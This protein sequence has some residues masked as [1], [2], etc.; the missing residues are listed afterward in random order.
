MKHIANRAIQSYKGPW[1]LA[2]TLGNV[3]IVDCS[4]AGC[5]IGYA[6]SK[7]FK[8]RT[9][10]RNVTIR[11]CKVLSRSLLG[12]AQFENICVENITG[13][14]VFV[15]GAV[16]K[17]VRMR[18]KF[19]AVV[20]HGL[21]NLQ[22]PLDARPSYWK[23]CD[24]F[25]ANCDW[26]LDIS[27]AEFGNFDIRLRGVPARL[28]VRDPETQAV[29]KAEKIADGRWRGMPL[30]GLAQFQLKMWESGGGEDLI[31][32]APKRNKAGFTE[33]LDD[34]RK[35]REAGIAEPD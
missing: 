17:H 32:V 6:H 10:V 20:I 18:G 22:T 27:E 7:D 35:L 14:E 12:P 11:D 2:R 26:A 29:I 33:V 25:Y 4:F 21:P 28:V 34:I 19:D 13:C 3:E 24:E 15:L 31:I 23:L 5:S 9:I 8:R 1:L 16:F 30:G